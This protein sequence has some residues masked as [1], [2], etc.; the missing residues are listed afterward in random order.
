MPI[1]QKKAVVIT[2]KEREE[3]QH[4]KRPEGVADDEIFGRTLYTLISP[5]TE[6]ASDYCGD[7]FPKFPGYA[8][9]ARVESTGKSVTMFKKDSLFFCAG[10]HRSFQQVK[11]TDAVPVPK[12]LSPEKAVLCRLMNVS[13]TTLMTT[14]ARPGDR[15]II[16]GAGP[17]GFLASQIFKISGYDVSVVEPM[18]ERRRNFSRVEGIRVFPKMPLNVEGIAGNIALVVECSGS[19]SAVLDA[20][21]V[22]RKKGEV[23]L[24]GVPWHRQTDIYALHAVF[25]RYVI[26]RSGW[27]WE[28]PRYSSDFKPHS[29]ISGYATALKWLA[30]GRIFTEGLVSLINPA[31]AQ[32]V[33]Q[34]LLHKEFQGLFPVFK[35]AK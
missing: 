4:I 10:G 22:V 12:G 3:L 11:E 23:V 28:L 19:E 9:V 26:L 14:S 7:K 16:S 34:R 20:C 31:D 33:Y 8:A 29:I 32:S 5:G 15:V 24:V 1:L 27:E 35:W 13:M 25:H 30:E 17:V 18:S 2:G 21:K 6:L